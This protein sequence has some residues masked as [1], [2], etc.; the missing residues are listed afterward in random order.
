VTFDRPLTGILRFDYRTVVSDIER[1][2]PVTL[3]NG[4]FGY[5]L[6]GSSGPRNPYIPVDFH[7]NFIPHPGLEYILPPNWPAA[8]YVTAELQVTNLTQIG[9]GLSLIPSPERILIRQTMDFVP[10]PAPIPEPAT[11]LLVASGLAIAARRSLKR[12]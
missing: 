3:N 4:G 2:G 10:S 9:F 1:W 12:R 5:V 8:G 6:A 7:F 11:L